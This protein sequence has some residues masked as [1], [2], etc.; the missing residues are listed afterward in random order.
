MPT[1]EFYYAR[2]NQAVL[3]DSSTWLA[4]YQELSENSIF[5]ILFDFQQ[6][7]ELLSR[8]VYSLFQLLSDLGGYQGLIQPIFSVMIGWYLSA[9][10]QVQQVGESMRILD[11]R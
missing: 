9:H 5:A 10:H 4:N 8:K 2:P 7:S 11:S 6:G 1:E 3:S